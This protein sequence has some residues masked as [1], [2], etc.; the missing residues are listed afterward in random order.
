MEEVNKKI[1]RLELLIED[2]IQNLQ[3]NSIE[4]DFVILG[5]INPE[6]KNSSILDHIMAINM[7]TYISC[8]MYIVK[9]II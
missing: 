3:E 2:L 7:S 4:K 6:P 8:F 1:E 5:D 9:K